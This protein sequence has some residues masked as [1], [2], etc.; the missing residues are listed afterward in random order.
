MIYHSIRISIKPDAPND[1]L[2][3]ALEL[4][5]RMGEIEAVESW[6]VGGESDYGAMF[7]LKDLIS[8]RIVHPNT[9]LQLAP[10]ILRSPIRGRSVVR[11]HAG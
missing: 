7:A 3:N 8:S 11:R 9:P 2:E 4:P 6:C 1:Q 5:R 10:G